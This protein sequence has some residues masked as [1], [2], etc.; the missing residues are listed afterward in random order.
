MIR[1]RYIKT[2][3]KNII[4]QAMYR[5]MYMMGVYVTPSYLASNPFIVFVSCILY[6]MLENTHTHA[7]IIY[8]IRITSMII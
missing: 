4:V 2:P 6:I 8:Y 3:Y 1:R 7:G 5:R